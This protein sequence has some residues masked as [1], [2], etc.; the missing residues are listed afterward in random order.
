VNF[1]TLR[2]CLNTVNDE[3][4]VTCSGSAFQTQANSLASKSYD[5]L[6]FTHNP[7]IQ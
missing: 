1:K 7:E 4:E 6:M 2:C 5:L 3:A